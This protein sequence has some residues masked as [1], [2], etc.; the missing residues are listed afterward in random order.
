LY[1]RGELQALENG[2][3]ASY[4]P[5]KT[6]ALQEL[7]ARRPEHEQRDAARSLNQLVDEVEQGIVGPVQ[8]LE[9]EHE[10][11]L[12]GQRLEEATPGGEA[13]LRA[14]GP[15]LGEAGERTQVAIEPLRL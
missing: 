6:R 2:A 13:L 15:L 7:R 9:H 5:T 12:V 10:R 8:I 1:S 4:E 14:G 11:P 3:G